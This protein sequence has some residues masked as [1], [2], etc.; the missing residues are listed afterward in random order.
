MP[1][2]LTYKEVKESVESVGYKILSTEYKNARTKLKLQCPKGHIFEMTLDNFKNKNTRCTECRKENMNKRFRKSYEEVKEYVESIGYEL[3]SKEYV[4]AHEKLEVKCPKGHKYEV[5]YANLQRGRRCP[6][7]KVSKGE[8]K[9]IDW[10]NKNDVKFIYDKPYFN[11]LLS[12]IGNPLKP[13][14]I[15]EDKRVWIEYDGAFHYKKMYDDDNYEILIIHDRIKDE[16]AKENNWKLIRIP[17]W[18]FDNIEEIL[19]KE[20]I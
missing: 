11:D 16:Y 8:Q 17:Y 1:K 19:E 3:L 2:K 9:I 15:I 7:C 4:N 13:D 20:L 6:Y 18:E 10:L 14:F 5:Q 12:P